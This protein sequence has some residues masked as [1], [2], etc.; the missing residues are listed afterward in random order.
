MAD[1]SY[2]EYRI[3]GKP[4]ELDRLFCI[5][6]KVEE[7]KGPWL[8]ELMTE[9]YG[10]E[11]T[12]ARGQWSKLKRDEDCISFTFEGA[13]RTYIEEWDE[14]CEN[15]ESLCPYFEGVLWAYELAR[16]RENKEKGW[17]PDKYYLEMRYAEDKDD[18]AG[19]FRTLKDVY[20]RI[21]ELTGTKVTSKKDVEALLA[22]LQEENEDTFILIYEIEEIPSI[23]DIRNNMCE[24]AKL[25]DIDRL[26]SLLKTPQGEKMTKSRCRKSVCKIQVFQH[27]SI[28]EH[29]LPPIETWIALEK[30]NH[31]Y[32]KSLI[33]SIE[34]K[35][36]HD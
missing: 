2:C 8:F 7:T 34:K 14:V 26:V 29:K 23:T 18:E 1:W 19:R 25:R 33:N 4:Q 28:G 5:M 21:E 9:I 3:A 11:D 12:D 6:Q 24:P 16:K 20:K 27:I 32:I 13:G 36:Q 10:D 22:A 17:F 15:F 35:I 31:D 30:L